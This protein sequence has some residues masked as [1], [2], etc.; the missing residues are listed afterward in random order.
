MIC[1][2]CGTEN[3]DVAKFCMA[4]AAPLSEKAEAE[5]RKLVSVLF[6]DLVGFTA[7]SDQADPED[8][9]ATLRPYHARVK[10]E[11][12][13][14]GGTVEK[15]VGDG[16]MAVFGA[17][18]GHGDDAERA[19]RAALRVTEAIQELNRIHPELDLAVRAAV[20]TGEAMVSVGA[21]LHEG[22][23]MVAGDVVNTASRLQQEAPVGGVVVGETT[24][25]ATRQSVD[26][27]PLQPVALKGKAEPVALWIAN[28]VRGEFRGDV[29][30]SETTPLIGREGELGHLRRLWE[31]TAADRRPHL[32]MLI[33][34]PGIGKSRL[35]WEFT[36]SV[37]GTGRVLTGRCRPYGETTGYGAFGQQL[38]QAAGIF[39]TD[40]A[41]T[42]EDRLYSRVA[43]LLPAEDAPEVAGHLGVLLGLPGRES[44]DKQIL[45]YSARRF[46]EALAKERPLVLATE[47]IHW[48][49]PA[50][51]E[52]LESLAGR[53]REVPLLMVT[54]ARPE[55]LDARPTWGG[56]LTSYTAIPVEPLSDEE[57]LDLALLHLSSSEVAAEAVNRL[58]LAA[59]GNPLFL[60]E[61]AASLAEGTAGV[62]EEVPTNV[63]AIIAARLD[64]LPAD[65]R[66][67]LQDA[68]V[69]GRVFWRG[70]LAAFSADRERLDLLLDSL[71]S[72]DFIRIQPTSRVAGD[73]EYLFKH[74][75][76][77]EVAYS[78]LPRA[79]RRE[80]HRMVAEFLEKEIGDRIGEQASLLAHHFREAG[81]LGKAAAFLLTAA[82]V[83]SRAWAKQ[84]AVQMYSDAIAL[85]E[86]LGDEEAATR[87]VIAR[88]ATRVDAGD[89]AGSVEDVDPV[90][91]R[92]AGHDLAA[93]LLARAQAAYWLTDAVSVHRYAE[94]AVE[95]AREIGDRELE[96]HALAILAEALGMD[97]ETAQ[98]LETLAQARSMWPSTAQDRS[99]AQLMAQGA[100]IH[101]WRG[102][103]E[104][105]VE[106]AKQGYEAGMAT[107]SI[108]ATLAA[109]SHVAV[110]LCGLSRHEEAL[111]WFQRTVQL[112]RELEQIP[113]LTARAVNMWSGT[114][115]ELGDLTGARELSE[116]ALELGTK[117]AFVGAEVSA[118]IDLLF[119]DIAERAIGK[120]REALPG[121]FEAAER[122]KGWH[123]WLWMG[124]LE[125]A[126][127]ELALA[128]GRWEEAAKAADAALRRAADSGRL[129]YT[130]LARTALGRA[131]LGL[132][133]PKEAEGNLRQAVGAAEQLRHAPSLWPALNGVSEALA[134]AGREAEAEE[135]R[136]RAREVLNGFVANLSEAHRRSLESNPQ[137]AELLS[138]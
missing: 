136:H 58:A 69:V 43:E 93:A 112:G 88:G 16:V 133:R 63:Q 15:F 134:A 7:R 100:I 57:A 34:P 11:I 77:R 35:L 1:G 50:L 102:E 123:Q 121:L 109:G 6:V 91:T 24:Y 59:G 114:L 64:S 52:L 116:Q 78:T 103:Y 125:Q 94:Q 25:R 8:V 44:P 60:E 84:E 127:A 70:A 118:R 31:Q 9:R 19:V 53:T 2:R 76:T 72:R 55:L 96:A 135:A 73:R 129:K 23:S 66:R 4:C 86:Q 97:G 17:P 51:L 56:G 104:Q 101:Y 113:R 98:A 108:F 39:A 33:G 122:T 110:A 124:R 21:S 65:E 13:R 89:L 54:L 62:A 5:E 45:F 27:E 87:A 20:N 79:S 105:A 22:E 106:L 26:F 68:S 99:Y 12:E 36:K 49:D 128:A 81:D 92:V 29:E 120:G 37:D 18:V 117:A 85:F 61:L 132:Q 14:F 48:A 3:P 42:A 130:C 126:R 83:A 90:L 75:L 115:R 30:P 38:Q 107:S 131:M 47:D 74:V 40:S 137:V 10:E 28:S 138:T 32:V 46:V 119:A 67:V 80:R 82:E 41:S 111:E 71:E 95:V